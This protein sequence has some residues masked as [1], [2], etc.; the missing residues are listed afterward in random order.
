M[1]RTDKNSEKPKKPSPKTAIPPPPN[2][3]ANAETDEEHGEGS[4]QG[5]RDYQDSL[6]SYLETANVDK[7]AREG[8]PGNAAEANA[9]EKAEQVGR[10]PGIRTQRKSRDN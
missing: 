9:L 7:D 6:K 3:S 10:R 2:S 5:T 4:Y 1:Q 8:A